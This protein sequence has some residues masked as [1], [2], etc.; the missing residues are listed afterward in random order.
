ML[1]PCF[2]VSSYVN[3]FVNLMRASHGVTLVTSVSIQCGQVNTVHVK[4]GYASSK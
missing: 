3:S 1:L 2:K 4:I